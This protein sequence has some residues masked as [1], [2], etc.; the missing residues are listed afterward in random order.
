MWVC[1]PTNTSVYSWNEMFHVYT[2]IHQIDCDPDNITIESMHCWIASFS[3][4]HARMAYKKTYVHLLQLPVPCN[5]F[6]LDRCCGCCWCC[7]T[8]VF[9]QEYQINDCKFSSVA[10]VAPTDSSELLWKF[11]AAWSTC[12]CMHSR[13]LHKW[14]QSNIPRRIRTIYVYERWYA[15]FLWYAISLHYN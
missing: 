4:N 3:K 13:R 9:E 11:S 12:L 10:N 6:V 14:A 1:R 15:F 5:A 8:Q 7:K 2:N